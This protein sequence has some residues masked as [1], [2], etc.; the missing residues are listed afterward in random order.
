MLTK[1]RSFVPGDLVQMRLINHPNRQTST[2]QLL[3]FDAP[4]MTTPGFDKKRRRAVYHMGARSVAIVVTTTLHEGDTYCLIMF[5]TCMGWVGA[6][7]V[8]LTWRNGE[9]ER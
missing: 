3:V 2:I 9:Y 1:P 8:E 6:W 7:N 5:G 4:G